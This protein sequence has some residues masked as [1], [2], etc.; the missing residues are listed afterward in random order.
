MHT[1]NV[2]VR[3]LVTGS[4]RRPRPSAPRLVAAGLEA[5]LRL[6]AP[7][8]HASTPLVRKLAVEMSVW[9]ELDD[10]EQTLV[11]LCATVRDVGM[12]S[13]PDAVIS[14]SGGLSPE[15]WTSINRHPVIGAEL[16]ETVPGLGITAP[17]VRAHH[18]RWDGGGDPD[19]LVGDAAPLLSRVIATADAFVAIASDRPHRSAADADIAREHVAELRGTQ[20]DPQAVAG[21]PDSTIFNPFTGAFSMVYA[22]T[23]AANGVTTVFIAA[24]QHYPNG[25]CAAAKNGKITS[26]PGASHLTVQAVGHPSQVY[27]SVTPGACPTSSS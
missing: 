25:W 8:L 1:V 4:D 27:I 10:R 16:L 3:E 15:Q 17:I 24:S 20:F 18:E 2:P 12:I 14:S 23:Q 6:R 11:E 19:G 26:K 9:L 21:D 5:A 13:L 22:P 7:R